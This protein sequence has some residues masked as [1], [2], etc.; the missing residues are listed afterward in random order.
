MNL[1]TFFKLSFYKNE[2]I[3]Y[4][5]EKPGYDEDER[6]FFF[7]NKLTDKIWHVEP[8]KHRIGPKLFSFDKKVVFNYWPDYPQ[9][10]TLE[11]KKLF[12]K[13]NPFWAEFR[14]NEQRKSEGYANM[15]ELNDIIDWEDKDKES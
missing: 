5:N 11:Q 8:E 4:G 10:L 12:D 15:T 9:N 14:K 1:R 13:E 6:F 3:F 7:K 2:L